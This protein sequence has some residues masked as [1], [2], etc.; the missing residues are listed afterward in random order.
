M[1]ICD[2][3]NWSFK[4]KGC[5]MIISHALNMLESLGDTDKESRQKIL[6]QIDNEIG[7]LR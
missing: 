6:N 5:R 1:K 2:Y 3:S 7:Y 4:S